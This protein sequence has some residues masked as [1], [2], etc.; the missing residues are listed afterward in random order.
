MLYLEANVFCWAILYDGPRGDGA[1]RILQDVV[2]G[3]QP[4]GTASPSIDE[5][6]W[7][8]QRERNRTLALEE[9]QRIMRLPN[10]EVFT[11]YSDLVTQSVDL[12]EEWDS[13]R[14]R[15]GLHAATALEHG[16][17][18]IAS[19]DSDFEAIPERNR[20]PLTELPLD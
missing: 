15:D 16:I 20:F 14:P 1:R 10:L 17:D 6:T 2:A 9:A 13:L 8:L 7:I 19:D 5:I 3:R 4:G 11:V 12:M 18:S